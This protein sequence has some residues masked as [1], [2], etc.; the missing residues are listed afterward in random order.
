[1]GLDYAF[2]R[3]IFPSLLE[4]AWVTVQISALALIFGTILGVLLGMLRMIGPAPVQTVIQWIVNYVRGVPPLIHIAYIFFALPRLGIFFNE[5]WTGVVALTIVTMG[6]LVEIVRASIESIDKGQR[7]AAL[8]I[9][10]TEW[11]TLRV[12]LLPQ[13]TRRMIPAIT[14]E[15]ANV[16][17]ASSLLSVIS[18]RE[19]TLVGNEIIYRNFVVIEVFIEVALLYLLV[20][21]TLMLASRYLEEYVFAFGDADARYDVTDIR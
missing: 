7:E 2:M 18:V 4:A 21:G 15:L 14:N 12:I 8:S 1:M 10:M 17:K 5:F 16:I 9:G 19:L 6:Y 3:E 11:K 20:V 13:A